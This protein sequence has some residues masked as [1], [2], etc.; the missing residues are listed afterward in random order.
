MAQHPAQAALVDAQQRVEDALGRLVEAAVLILARAARRKRLHSIGVSVSDTTPEIRM[1]TQMV[2][3][4][5]WNSRP[6]MPGMNSTGMNTAA[7]D[8]VIERIVKPIS[9]RA[10]ERR[11]ERRL[12]PSPCGGRCSRA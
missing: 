3:A 10:V 5:S 7:S 11:L 9:L 1:A 8:S 12:R 2:T 4:N 6:R